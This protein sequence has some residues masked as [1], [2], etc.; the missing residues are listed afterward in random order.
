MTVGWGRALAFA[1][2]FVSAGIA[3]SLVTSYDGF[4][5]GDGPPPCGK[6]VPARPVNASPGGQGDL[7]GVASVLRFT[8]DPDASTLGFDLDGVCTCPGAGSCRSMKNGK[9][10]PCD[11]PGTG[12]DNAGG[13]VITLLY[14]GSDTMA[15]GLQANIDNGIHGV[16]LKVSGW[17]GQPDDPDVMVSLYN[18]A[19]VDGGKLAYDGRDEVYAADE[20]ILAEPL[21][22]RYYDPRAY[23]TGG[24]LVADIDFSLRLVI[25]QPAADAAQEVMVPLH[26]ARLVG[27]LKKVSDTGVEMLD[28]QL[29]GRL[30]QGDVFAQLGKLGICQGTAEYDGL[31]NNLCT[32]LDIASNATNDGKDTACD[33]LSFAVG[34]VVKP[35]RLTGHVPTAPTTPPCPAPTDSCQ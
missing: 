11:P 23:V 9:Q 20:S 18:V 4:T 19:G 31:K 16:V 30:P 33:A 27:R 2:V 29:V 8:D 34:L 24:V 28:A 7:Y 1:A 5:P 32:A 21:G 3:C 22:S 35:A 14:A 15:F 6:R 17:N 10:G 26:T 13:A 25:L 12:V